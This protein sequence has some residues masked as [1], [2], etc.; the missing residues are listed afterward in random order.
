MWRTVFAVAHADGVIS[1]GEVRMM[2]ETIEDHDFSEEQKDVL[3]E[4]IKNPQDPA[5]MFAK[6]SDAR[7][8]ANFFKF[9]REM[10]WADGDFGEDEQKILTDLIGDH[11]KT[12][13]FDSLVGNVDLELDD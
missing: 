4:D 8:Q 9:A 3:T 1:G 5:E 12:V 6:I 10:V 2:V 7:D 13:D 11:I